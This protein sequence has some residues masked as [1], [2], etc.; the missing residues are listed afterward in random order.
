M[1]HVSNDVIKKSG[2]GNLDRL[3]HTGKSIAVTS[4]GNEI[5]H[6]SHLFIVIFMLPE[7]MLVLRS[8]ELSL[9]FIRR[10]TL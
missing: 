3:F 6:S 4:F 10:Q 1:E 7:I 8:H 5:Q 9:I 2:G